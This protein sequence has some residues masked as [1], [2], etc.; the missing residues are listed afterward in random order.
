MWFW[1]FSPFSP[2]TIWLSMFLLLPFSI[3]FLFL[4][5]PFW[6]NKRTNGWFLVIHFHCSLGMNDTWVID[7]EGQCKRE[8]EETWRNHLLHL[9]SWVQ[10]P[11]HLAL[12]LMIH[13]WCVFLT[14]IL[15]F[16][17]SCK[18]KQLLWTLSLHLT[19][20]FSL[21]FFQINKQVIYEFDEKAFSF[22]YLYSFPQQLF[23]FGLIKQPEF[24][25]LALKSRER[26]RERELNEVNKIQIEKNT[27]QF[28]F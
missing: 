23:F 25:H 2:N 15:A 27:S 5:V 13:V 20:P 17:L 10:I 14:L 6:R 4:L 9:T 11:L 22:L 18:T 3:F 8:G 19:L 16:K 21:S 28:N 26:E 12:L 7:G 1:P 24:A